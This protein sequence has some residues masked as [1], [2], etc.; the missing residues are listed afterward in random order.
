MDVPDAFDHLPSLLIIHVRDSFIAS[1]G[2][3]RQQPYG[4]FSILSSDVQD[5]QMTWVNQVSAHSDVNGG[6]CFFRHHKFFTR[7]ASCWQL[8]LFL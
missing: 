5:V 3:V 4:D 8:L 1:D 7:P 2:L 6:V